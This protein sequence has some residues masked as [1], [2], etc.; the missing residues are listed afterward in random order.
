MGEKIKKQP[1]KKAAFI[2]P[3]LDVLGGAEKYLLN[4]ARVLKKQGYEVELFWPKIS[5]K[6]ELIARFGNQFSF[7]KINDTFNKLSPLQ[8]LIQTKNYDV[9]F[10]HSDGSYFCSLAKKNFNLY[11][12]PKLSLMQP[13]NFFRKYKFSFWTPIFNSDFTKDF[14]LEHVKTKK[15]HVLYPTIEK[16]QVNLAEKQRIILSVGRFFSH[17][18]SKRQDVLIKAFISGQKNY[19]NF[20]DYKLVLVGAFRKEDQQYLDYLKK[21]VKNNSNIKILTNISRSQIEGYYKHASIYWAG[22]GYNVDE[23]KNPELVEHFGITVIEAEN[24]GC[25]PVVYNAGGH[26]ETVE[27]QK[28][29]YLYKTE[30]QLLDYTDKLIGNQKLREQ[31]ALLAHKQTDKNYG[32]TSFSEK[33]NQ[34]L[35]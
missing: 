25:V 5:I 13:T 4:I 34:I 8:K 23:K 27:H 28:T 7:I 33:L 17:L 20:R 32:Q 26:K 3:Y 6:K 15:Y 16:A 19:S 21:L 12:V 10:Y 18:H 22:A 1:M 11:Q 31:M 9:I 14:Y 29:G 24:Y 30:L 35:K 2:S